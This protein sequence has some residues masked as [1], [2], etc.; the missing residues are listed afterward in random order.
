ML[1]PKVQAKD[2]RVPEQAAMIERALGSTR[3]ASQVF[4][5]LFGEQARAQKKQVFIMSEMV[6]CM[7]MASTSHDV[8]NL[9]SKQR[10]SHR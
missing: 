8:R 7:A 3:P 4:K 6:S 5:G 10:G 2:Q 9:V 1:Q